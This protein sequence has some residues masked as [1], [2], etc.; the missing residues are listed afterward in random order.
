MEIKVQIPF[1]QLLTLVKSLTP[2]QKAKL[3]KELDDEAVK[4]QQDS[5]I[6]FLLNGPVYSREDINIIE[7]NRKS[8]AA[9][10]TKS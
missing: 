10:R 7:E 1:Q 5:F 6:D 2:S 4:P 9:W 8:I 3:K